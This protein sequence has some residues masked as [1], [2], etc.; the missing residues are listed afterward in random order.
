MFYVNLL[1]SSIPLMSIHE[2]WIKAR[3]KRKLKASTTPEA[4]SEIWIVGLSL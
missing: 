3:R 2:A 1:T 4:T